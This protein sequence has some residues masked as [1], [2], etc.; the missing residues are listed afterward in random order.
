MKRKQRTPETGGLGAFER[1]ALL[2]RVM[3]RRGQL[4]YPGL[5]AEHGI[6]LVVAKRELRQA[7][8]ELFEVAG[9][10][11]DTASWH[12]LRAWAEKGAER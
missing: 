1:W 7:E 2:N 5:A 8:A 10:A 12:E 4:D 6:D 9:L 11:W 3:S